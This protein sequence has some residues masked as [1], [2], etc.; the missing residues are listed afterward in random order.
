VFVLISS[1][2]DELEAEHRRTQANKLVG[3]YSKKAVVGAIA[4]MTPG[5]DL[6]I[7]GYLATQLVKELSRLY[8]VPVRQVDI[9]LLI[10]L[11]QKYAKTHYTLIL[12]VAGNA[13]KAFPGAGTLAG[14]ALHAVAYGFLFESLGRG[15]AGTLEQRGELNPVITASQ[16]KKNLSTNASDSAARFAK[17]AVKQLLK[18]K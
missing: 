16:V 4:A 15:V 12:A 8:E 1:K 10:E 7:Q 14:G 5:T 11:V 9:D 17:L 6:L 3:S 2:L 13:L 18:T